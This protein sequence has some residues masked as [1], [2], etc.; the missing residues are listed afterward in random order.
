L[1]WRQAVWREKLIYEYS[2]GGKT[3]TVITD[4]LKEIHVELPETVRRE[5]V[6]ELPEVSEVEVARH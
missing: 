3:G 4:D 1:E 6:L 5:S 2:S